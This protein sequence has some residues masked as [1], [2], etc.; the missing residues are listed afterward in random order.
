MKN[1]TLIMAYYNNPT[2]LAEHYSKWAQWG[3]EL[4]EWVDIIVVDDGSRQHPAVDVPRPSNLPPL[5]IYRVHDDLPWHQNGA[6]NLGALRAQGEWLLLTDMDHVFPESTL[7]ALK[8]KRVR[9]MA[10]YKFHRLNVGTLQPT[11]D[12]VGNPKPHPNTWLMT[13]KLYWTLGGYDERTCGYYGT[14]SIFRA[15]MEKHG[16]PIITL[17]IPVLKYD[18]SNIPDATTH[19]LARKQ[20]RPEGWRKRLIEKLNASPQPDPCDFHWYKVYPK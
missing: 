2:M 6:R 5:Q 17:K 18:D 8:T 9:E 15:K 19:G 11:L 12:R 10:V 1:M 4:R 16:A 13:K 7:L 20:G 3:P 14:D